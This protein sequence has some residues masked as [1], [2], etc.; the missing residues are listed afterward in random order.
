[1]L[2]RINFFVTE[3]PLAPNTGDLKVAPDKGKQQCKG[4]LAKKVDLRV[5]NF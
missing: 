1:M 5:H 2:H 3:D 4:E